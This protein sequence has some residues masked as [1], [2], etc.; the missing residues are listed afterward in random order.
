MI[1]SISMELY[2][3]I[4]ISRELMARLA[5]VRNE[6]QSVVYGRGIVI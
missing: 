3:A 2:K 6:S 5:G 4:A 1:S